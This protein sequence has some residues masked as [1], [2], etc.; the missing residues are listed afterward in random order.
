MHNFRIH[1][2]KSCENILARTL[3]SVAS[4]HTPHLPMTLTFDQHSQS[5]HPLVM[6][7]MSAMF[8]KD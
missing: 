1:V 8:N 6:V 4:M 3:Q 2:K 7:N 5:V